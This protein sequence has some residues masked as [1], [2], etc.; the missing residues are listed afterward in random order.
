MRARRLIATAVVG[1]LALGC[2]D[3][4][5]PVASPT[6][7]SI[8]TAQP[9]GTA[10]PSGEG[11][12]ASPSASSAQV[13]PRPSP[14]PATG[15]TA[16][17]WRK[18]ARLPAGAFPVDVLLWRGA[19]VAL[20]TVGTRA[21]A[22]TSTD[23]A[24][25]TT[26]SVD[27]LPLGDA[28]IG[29]PA[30]APGGLVSLG[31]HGREHCTTGE[32]STCDPVPVAV[33][34]SADGRSWHGRAAPA[35]FAGATVAAVAAGPG[36]IVA[37]GDTGWDHPAIWF[38]ADGAAWSRES[39][40]AA[41]FRHAVFHGLTLFRGRWV[42]T[43]A[44]DPRKPTCCGGNSAKGLNAAAWFSADG[45]S[46]SRAGV[47][48][49]ADLWIDAPVAGSAGL[50]A[51]RPSDDYDSNWLSSDGRSWR[52]GPSGA[53]AYPVAGDGERVIGYSQGDGGG[54]EL[55]VSAD[56]SSWQA[57]ADAGDANAKPS[58]DGVRHGAANTYFLLPTGLA[59]I[60]SDDSGSPLWLA[61]P[62]GAQ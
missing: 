9:S 15:W 2:G 14:S 53:E 6:T 51:W 50:V 7:P 29:L 23:F 58:W 22:W 54:L 49:A 61:T 52:P 28:R 37:V 20:G 3:S 46:W 48:S 36:G 32:G 13:T 26:A 30:A 42:L 11:P 43:G 17:S 56:G 4:T 33:W 31:V 44:T 19:Y 55:W 21:A 35:A 5:S 45:R 59:V 27:G 25:W 8:V 12:S 41:L 39:L 24:T 57:L 10:R 34:M 16:L 38:S 18:P 60:G 40:P 62:T 47:E 1:A